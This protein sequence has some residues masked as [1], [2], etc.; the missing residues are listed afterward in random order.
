MKGS[1]W[2]SFITAAGLLIE[3]NYYS[4]TP[5]HET[6]GGSPYSNV[7]RNIVLELGQEVE[8]EDPDEHA[9]V[10][11]EEGECGRPEVRLLVRRLVHLGDHVHQGDV[12]E[13][14]AGDGEDVLVGELQLAEDDPDEEAEV[15]GARGEKIVGQSL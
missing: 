12:E 1:I 4:V 14:A 3:Q 9:N 10:L 5:N 6:K 11:E 15:A 7:K 8:G 13:H 2:K